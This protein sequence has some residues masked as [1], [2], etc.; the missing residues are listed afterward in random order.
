[1]TSDEQDP[2]NSNAAKRD[3]EQSASERGGLTED[4][5]TVPPFADGPKP[6]TMYGMPA[7]D[8]F[9]G[10]D[11][12]F[13]VTKARPLSRLGYMDYAVVDSVFQMRRPKA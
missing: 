4:P 3:R 1:M 2:S 7:L 9:G 11:G 10:V 12:L 5:P 6:Q 13:D 8:V